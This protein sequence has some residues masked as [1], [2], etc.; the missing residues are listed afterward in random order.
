MML[1]PTLPQQDIQKFKL[2]LHLALTFY[3]NAQRGGGAA[4]APSSAP[5]A[6]A[7]RR[8]LSGGFARCE[9]A[10]AEPAQ[11][12]QW[13]LSLMLLHIGTA[14]HD[15]AHAPPAAAAAVAD[16]PAAATAALARL[17]LQTCVL[18]RRPQ[19]L[20]ERAFPLFAGADPATR[21]LGSFLE[22]IEP[23]VVSEVL[24]VRRSAAVGGWFHISPMPMCLNR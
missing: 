7:A 11:L 9:G 3:K 14:M 20:F 15:L 21:A 6:P 13:I 2:G 8:P 24:Q 17:A 5:G 16:D 12:E 1:Q 19:V 10:G 22:V 4:S 23:A 18:L